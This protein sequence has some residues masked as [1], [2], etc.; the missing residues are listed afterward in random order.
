[1]ADGVPLFLLTFQGLTVF[2]C[3]RHPPPP[4]P[5]PPPP[6]PHPHPHPQP[7]PEM[8]LP[9]TEESTIIVYVP[10]YVINPEKDHFEL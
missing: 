6:T 5:P 4:P 9:M 2:G 7:P 8:S 10:H 1:M 3:K